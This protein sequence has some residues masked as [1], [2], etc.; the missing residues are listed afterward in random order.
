MSRGSANFFSTF[1]QLFFDGQ[2]MRIY[3]GFSQL[4]RNMQHLRAQK[5]RHRRMP[6]TVFSG[7]FLPVILRTA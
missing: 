2:N 7:V 4:L 5:N 6:T 1:F 3:W